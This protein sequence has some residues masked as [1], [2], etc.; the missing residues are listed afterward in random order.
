MRAR[1]AT[2]G[3][4]A[5]ASLLLAAA[6]RV[7]AAREAIYPPYEVD[8]GSLY[9]SGGSLRRLTAG[10]NGL[11]ADVYWIRAILHY[12][13]TKRRLA[14]QPSAPAPRDYGLLY[15]LL[16]ITTT[17]DP[18]FKIAYRFGSVF[19][20]EAFPSGSGRPDLAIQLLEKGVRAQ[21]ERWE[22][23]QDIG[24]VHYWYRHDYRAAAEW[25]GRAADAPGAPWWLRS[26][27]ASTLAVGG[28]RQSS[29][30]MWEAIRQSAD[31]DWLRQ[32][33]ERRLLQLQALDVIDQLQARVGEFAHRAGRSPADW[34]EVIRAGLLR[35]VPLD[36]AG[37]PYD[38]APGGRVQLSERSALFP[39]PV[40]P[41]SVLSAP[42]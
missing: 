26:L 17:L 13:G 5:L 42:S 8:D 27:A 37:T 6:A 40:E 38:L 3:V 23:L 18:R 11:T 20:A 1:L 2:L 36:P 16:D 22:Y 9:L 4:I 14:A 25:F 10:F 7:Q 29:R 24:F 35:S 19:L 34:A 28:D 30:V 15:P 39:L 21:P 32:D 12:G 31:N 41:G 33:A